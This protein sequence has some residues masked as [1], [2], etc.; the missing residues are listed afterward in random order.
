MG[1][2]IF[3]VIEA[4]AIIPSVF[5]IVSIPMTDRD[6]EIYNSILITFRL[7]GAVHRM[8]SVGSQEFDQFSD[9]QGIELQQIEARRWLRTLVERGADLE[10]IL[11]RLVKH[12]RSMWQRDYGAGYIGDQQH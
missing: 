1:D 12:C 3:T 5:Y 6:F 10:G 11:D 2:E 8:L 7:P 4:D 9:S